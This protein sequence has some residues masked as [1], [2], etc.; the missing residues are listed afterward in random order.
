MNRRD[1]LCR[2]G[3]NTAAVSSLGCISTTF[4]A[5]TAANPASTSVPAA[6]LKPFKPGKAKSI[7]QIWLWGGPSH[8]DTFDPKPEAGK[9]YC[10]QYEKP[11]D[12][13]A[14][15]MKLSP[16]MP[17][18]AAQ[19]DKFSI[20]RS[21]THGNNN[22]EQA[23]YI[24]QTG[25]EPG[26]GISYPNIGAI[27]SLFKG[28]DAGYNSPLPPY[29]VLTRG[30]GRFSESGFLGQKYKPFVTGGNPNSD[31]FLVSGFVVRGLTP[32]RQKVRREMLNQFDAMELTDPS[33]PAYEQIDGA[34]GHAYDL[35]QGD[36]AKTFN[37]S[38]EDAAVREKYGR[39][40]FG[41]SCLMAR[42]LVEAG[43]PYVTINSSGWDMHKKI[44]DALNKRLPEV[45]KGVAALLDDLAKRK[46]LDSTVIWMCGEFGRTPKVDMNAP[47]F[48]GRGHHGKCF[49]AMVAGG[50]FKGG[51][52][53]GA[54]DD[55]GVAVADRPVKMQ[56][57][58]G[59]ILELTGI[60]PDAKLPNTRGYDVTVQPP[61]SEAGRLRE[62][63]G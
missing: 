42:R 12:S 43:V 35:I 22:H 62:I 30:Q 5:D 19:A 40:E 11:I 38:T 44:F 6:P 48:G 1:F 54:S 21:V 13:A 58:L 26:S 56:D 28:V 59:S 25:H 50:G 45:D 37:L 52:I 18:L 36:A 61:E 34:V 47:W 27:V 41:Q 60:N 29:I 24:V 8:I 33:N 53:V 49:S 3:L 14:A 7:I 9:D 51:K 16:M 63:I 31:P 57:L 2:S 23:C 15:G 20:V 4:A 17:L 10:G 46:L 39:N 32:E 55:K